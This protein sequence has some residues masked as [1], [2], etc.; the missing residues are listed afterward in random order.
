MITTVEE[1]RKWMKDKV[2]VRNLNLRLEVFE[3]QMATTSLRALVELRAEFWFK[4]KAAGEEDRIV[5]SNACAS[6][7]LPM[8][9]TNMKG[10]VEYLVERVFRGA[11]RQIVVIS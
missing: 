6:V 4:V 9:E 5:G 10:F 8:E 2:E 3:R 7:T 1:L 11:S